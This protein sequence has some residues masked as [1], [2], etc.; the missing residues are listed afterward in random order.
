MNPKLQ[1]ETASNTPSITGF[2]NVTIRI[3][4]FFELAFALM[5]SK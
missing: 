2:W 5:A 1:R 4:L 3:H